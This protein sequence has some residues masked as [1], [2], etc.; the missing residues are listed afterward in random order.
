MH[1]SEIVNDFQT[2][3]ETAKSDAERYLSDHLPALA[4]LAEH[5]AGNPLVDA[6]MNAAHLSPS[7][8]QSFADLINRA[9]ADLAA[10]QPPPP[11]PDP[12]APPAETAAAPPA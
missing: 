6:V 5:A 8:L 3:F 4:G 9:E 2:H 10:L 11:A 7:M 1:L 12:A